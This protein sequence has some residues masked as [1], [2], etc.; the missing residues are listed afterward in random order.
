MKYLAVIESFHI[1]WHNFSN[2]RMG[3]W[4]SCLISTAQELQ[5]SLERSGIINFLFWEVKVSMR[6]SREGTGKDDAQIT[7]SLLKLRCFKPAAWILLSKIA[8]AFLN[9]LQSSPF[10]YCKKS[11]AICPFSWLKLF[12]AHLSQKLHNRYYEFLYVPKVLY[13]LQLKTIKCKIPFNI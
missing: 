3:A 9:T 12:P 13:D 10:C 2:C 8:H 5:E 4:P 1:E 11:L 6:N 7:P